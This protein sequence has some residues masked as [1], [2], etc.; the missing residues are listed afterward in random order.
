V[1]AQIKPNAAVPDKIAKPRSSGG[2]LAASKAHEAQ[3][4]ALRQC[5]QTHAA[6]NSTINPQF[7]N[8]NFLTTYT[9]SQFLLGVNG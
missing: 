1:C 8:R 9:Q 2:A 5:D 4:V 7:L 6:A 3:N